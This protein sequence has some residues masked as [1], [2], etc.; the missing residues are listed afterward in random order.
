MIRLL[1]PALYLLATVLANLAFAHFMNDPLLA[2]NLLLADFVI[3][4]LLIGVDM[5][6]R[7][8][9]HQSWEGRGLAWKMGLL[10]LAG[11]LLSYAINREA[12][13]VAKASFMAFFVAGVTDAL[14]FQ[15]LK[16]RPALIRANGSNIPSA[17]VDSMAFPLMAFGW[18]LHWDFFAVELAAKL[19]GGALWA[20]IVFHRRGECLSAA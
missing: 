7:D 5:G 16:G 20:W 4:F 2:K 15:A 9:L 13:V 14:V 17:A 1:F 6:L 12:E 8:R 3:C 18:P 19:L 11:S 10:I